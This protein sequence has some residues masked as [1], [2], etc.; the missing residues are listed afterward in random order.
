[1]TRFTSEFEMGSGGSMSLWMPSKLDGYRGVAYE[2][3][4]PILEK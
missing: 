4:H 1:M 2:L 3:A